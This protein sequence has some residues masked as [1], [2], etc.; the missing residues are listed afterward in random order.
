MPKKIVMLIKKVISI[1]ILI[2]IIYSCQNKSTSFSDD[3]YFIKGDITALSNKTKV[4]LKKQENG[5]TI[6][7]DSTFSENGKF[8]FSGIIET[9]AMYGI[10]IDSIKGGI[11]P[12]V[13]SGTITINAHKDSLYNPRVSGTK[14]NNELNVFKEGSKKI[15]DKINDL[16]PEFQ[17]ARAENDVEKID[18][19][20]A[21]MKAIN[22]ENTTYSL[23]YTK[24]NPDSYISAMILQ[25]L[26]RMP[27]MNPE[28]A[29][30][31]YTN[32]SDEVKKSDFSKSIKNYIERDMVQKDSI[33]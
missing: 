14:L 3:N 32:F 31:I 19:I 30:L 1:S 16:F 5:I 9:P 33:N 8:E 23:N 25:S 10:F 7:I 4:L 21:E 26:L 6:S 28:K 20:N 12:L 22:D 18:Q 11:Y 2:L 13:E 17:K 15:V 29:K 24:N 27:D